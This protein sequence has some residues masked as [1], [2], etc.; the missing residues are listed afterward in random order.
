MYIF[1]DFDGVLRRSGSEPSRFEADCLDHFEAAVRPLP[2]VRIV[3]SSTW[4]L[5]MSLEELGALF[6]PEVAAMVVAVT[7]EVVRP[8]TPWGRHEEIQ[9]FLAEQGDAD[10]SWVAIDDNADEFPTDAPLVRVDPDVGF[11][12]SDA[13]ELWGH[14]ARALAS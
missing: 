4:R 13:R 11:G 9:Q 3:I 5:V 6:S 12:A 7:P 8:D 2:G 10:G 14:A 1:L